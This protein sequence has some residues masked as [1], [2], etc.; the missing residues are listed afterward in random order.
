MKKAIV[1]LRCRFKVAMEQ[2][3]CRLDSIL[4][5]LQNKRRKCKS[6]GNGCSIFTSC[7]TA[8]DSPR[9][10]LSKDGDVDVRYTNTRRHMNDFFHTLIDAKWQWVVILFASSFVVSWFIFAILW[11]IVVT[12]NNNRKCVDNVNDWMS[13][14]LFSIELQSTIGFGGRAVTSNCV[15]GV[16]LLIIQCLVGMLIT[17][18]MFGLL[19]MKITQ[20]NSSNCGKATLFSRQAVITLHKGIYCL[21]FRYVDFRR[22]RLL[23]S[24]MRLAM[25]G[26]KKTEEGEYVPLHVTDMKITVDFKQVDHTLCFSPFLPVTIIHL[27]DPSSPLF[28]M[29][30][31]Q[32]EKADFEL[33]VILEGMIPT[34][35]STTQAV[36]SYKPPEILW[37][38]QF[39]SLFDGEHVIQDVDAIDLSS[40]H[41]T[42]A[43]EMTMDCSA[44]DYHR[45]NG[46]TPTYSLT[47][48]ESLEGQKRA[49]DSVV[50][51]KWRSAGDL[52]FVVNMLG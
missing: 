1:G 43:E 51:P 18:S 7:A 3:K 38:H 20:P 10:L 39:K 30:K 4:N 28:S 40:L 16:L 6:R 42:V 22:R 41:D 26:E 33:V 35:G 29:S 50:H 45:Q 31:A 48:D 52:D 44:A 15:D 25:I 46:I 5:M 13:A 19:F 14:I 17:C 32:L 11:Y 27:I 8:D 9:R 12:A 36:T 37:G 23:S 21:M 47:S 49:H 34:T 24:N 2:V